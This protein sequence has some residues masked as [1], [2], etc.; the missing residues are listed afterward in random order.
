MSE[1]SVG[2]LERA[3]DATGEVIA[4]VRRAQASQSTPC[5]DSVKHQLTD[6][7]VHAWDGARAAGV[8]RALDDDVVQSS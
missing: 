6:L 4:Q 1:N 2:R 3:L 7:A 8:P 5:S